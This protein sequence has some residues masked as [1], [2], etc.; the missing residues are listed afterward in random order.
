M[1]TD[2]QYK[3]TFWAIY[4]HAKKLIIK[5]KGDNCPLYALSIALVIYQGNKEKQQGIKK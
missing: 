1:A 2:E 4:I 3:S 5:Q